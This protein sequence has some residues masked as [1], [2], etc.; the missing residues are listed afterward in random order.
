MKKS[1]W[2]AVLLLAAVPAA[3]LWLPAGRTS[4]EAQAA[5]DAGGAR[6]VAAPGVVEPASEE[7][8]I[9]AEL[10]GVLAEVLTD[11]NDTVRAGQRLAVLKSAELEARLEGARAELAL[12]ESELARLV[13]G[14]RREE[15]NEAAA[16]L[17]EAE[18]LAR[19]RAL[20]H[21]R[22]EKLHASGAVSGAEHDGSREA[23]E[24][25]RARLRAAEERL[26]LVRA[27]ARADEIAQFKARI[28]AARAAV[29]EVEAMLA[30]TVIT[31][32]IDG[33]VLRRFK[34]A[35]ETVTVQPVTPIFTIGD[36]SRLRVRAEIDEVDVAKIRPGRRVHVTAEAF[37]GERFGGTVVRVA[38]RLGAKSIHSER[39]SEKTDTKILEAMVELDPEVKLPVGLRVDVF[40]G[41]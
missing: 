7:R 10:G 17:A 30:K 21:A 8:E 4:G 40:V 22:N 37:R 12:R 18:A 20:D 34:E 19:L 27:P 28:A 31:S 41:E 15:R 38:S 29:A 36:L 16:R 1:R 23:L 24:S 32:P 9:A 2:L 35:G 3:L 33:T 13:N 26:A 39:P 11:E 14:A 6:V 5:P 25:A